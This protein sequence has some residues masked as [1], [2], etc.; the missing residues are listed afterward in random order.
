MAI[1]RGESSGNSRVISDLDTTACTTP[2]R[3]KPRMSAHSISHVIPKA[4]AR[5]SNK[6]FTILSVISLAPH[7]GKEF[8][9]SAFVAVAPPS[10]VEAAGYRNEA[11]VRFDHLF[12]LLSHS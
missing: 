10:V 3:A 7:H 4:R 9:A 11:Q 1:D 6:P 12:R 5:A 8:I 2:D